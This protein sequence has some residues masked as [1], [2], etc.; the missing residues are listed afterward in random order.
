MFVLLIKLFV[1]GKSPVLN[2][3]APAYD[4]FVL[5]GLMIRQSPRMTTELELTLTTLIF[6]TMDGIA[7]TLYRIVI[8]IVY[9]ARA[10]M[11][12]GIV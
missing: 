9:V 5:I 12:I 3:P 2:E 7:N 11:F 10:Q 4:L 8:T 1:F 6:P